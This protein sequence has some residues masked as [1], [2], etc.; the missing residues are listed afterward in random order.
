MV[1]SGWVPT[2]VLSGGCAGADT[3]GE[4]WAREHRIPVQQHLA[5]VEKFG[6]AYAWPRRNWEM[7][8]EADALVL[9]WDG[10]SRGSANML[11]EAGLRK[12]KVCEHRVK[13]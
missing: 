5:Q 1:R 6:A 7:A 9:I 4:R 8:C 11:Y 2:L 10:Q 12:L 3:L 13:L